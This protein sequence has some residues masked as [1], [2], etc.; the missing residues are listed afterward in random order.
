MGAETA[1]IERALGAIG[2][3]FRLTRLYP[4]S[5]PAVVEA[6]R[7]GTAALP[8]GAA[9]GTVEWKI[10]ATGLHWQGQQLLPRNGQLAE[11]A[12]LLFARGIRS[13]KVG[14]AVTAEH[15]LALFG[16]ATG[17]VRPDD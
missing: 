14:P 16:V 1:G 9:A 3:T 7:Q 11:L 8:A 6:L 13:I 4:P 17:G 15:V 10:G 5:H 12:G 2:T